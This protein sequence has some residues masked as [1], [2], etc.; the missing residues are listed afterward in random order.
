[1]SS[2]LQLVLRA[3]FSEFPR[4]ESGRLCQTDEAYSG[5]LGLLY[6]IHYARYL[7]VILTTPL[8]IVSCIEDC[9]RNYRDEIV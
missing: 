8:R 7:P 4:Q 5:F 6:E 3:P 9:A 2:V 1:M